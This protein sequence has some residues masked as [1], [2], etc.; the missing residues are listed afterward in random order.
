MRE[1]IDSSPAAAARARAGR[2]TLRARAGAA[3]ILLF[4]ILALPAVSPAGTGAGLPAGAFVFQTAR[5]ATAHPDRFLGPAGSASPVAPAAFAS[6]E[7]STAGFLQEGLSADRAQR[8]RGNSRALLTALMSAVVPGAGQLRNGS[9]L[10]GLG[11][12]AVEISG[13]VA[14]GAFQQSSREKRSEYADF[15]GESWDYGRYH[16]R[17]P[18]PDSCSAYGCPYGHWSGE[19]DEEILASMESP[20][21]D[22]FHEYITREAYACGWDTPSSRALYRA[23]W[24]DRESALDA[25]RWTGRVIFLNHLV[26]AVDAFIEARSMRLDLDDQT[27]LQLRMRGSF[28]SLGPEVRLTHYF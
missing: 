25:K 16:T 20:D 10:R 26:S 9:L 12:F 7:G 24:S 4:A 11:Y 23:L 27:R 18:D 3:A 14:Y 8:R 22:R 21:L 19:S 17:A 5:P 6:L 1:A 13:W 28:T 2:G 15:A